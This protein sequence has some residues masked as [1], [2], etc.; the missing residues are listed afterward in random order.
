[1]FVHHYFSFDLDNTIDIVGISGPVHLFV[2]SNSLCF[3]PPPSPLI[4]TIKTIIRTLHD[5]LILDWT[6]FHQS[7][8]LWASPRS[9]FEPQKLDF[10]AK[11]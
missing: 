1:M 6:A 11:F 4:P 9:K 3:M 2:L 7:Q 8:D 5:F 10:P